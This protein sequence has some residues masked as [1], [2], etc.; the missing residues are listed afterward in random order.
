MVSMSFSEKERRDR[1]L[2]ILRLLDAQYP[3]ARILLDYRNPF[4]LL[5]ATIL[6]AQCTDERV[7][8]VT[9]PLFERAPD[10]LAM[11]EMPLDELEEMIHSTGFFRA[12]AKSLHNA[13]ET[14]V[15]DY[16]GRVPESI[17]ELTKVPGVGRKTANV[18]AGN[19]FDKPAIIV[20]THFKRV[21]GR[22]RLTSQTNPDKI[23]K[24]IRSIMPRES[25]TRFSYV[26]NFHGR[27]CCRSRKP[28]CPHCAI[29]EL[30]PYPDKTEQTL[31]AC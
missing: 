7:N 11:A 10:P 6:A 26:I 24:G 4:E 2:E 17:E 12:K 3:D 23:E 30:C 15:K 29:R 1:G 9:K 21:V 25:Q 31:D 5:V 18:I 13:S 8:Q 20:D 28:D 16:D 27:Y 14:L 19:C 22:L